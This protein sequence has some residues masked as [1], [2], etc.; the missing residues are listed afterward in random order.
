MENGETT[1]HYNDYSWNLEAS[2]LYIESPGGVGY[3][4][5]GSRAECTFDDDTSATDNLNAILYFF[6]TLF[7]EFVANDLYISGESY[8]GIY[9][10]YVVNQIDT[11]NKAA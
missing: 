3:S 9:V 5:C 10:P 7:P 6:N 8:A 4:T 2:M 11:Y 1:F